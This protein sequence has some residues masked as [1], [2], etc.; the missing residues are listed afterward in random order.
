MGKRK[1]YSKEYK[2]EA[3]KLVREGGKPV[4]QAAQDLGITQTT[5][6]NWLRQWGIDRGLGP[7]NALTTEEKIEMRRLRA[8]VRQLTMERDF[9]KKAAAFFAKE[10]K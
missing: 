3:V 7:A 1:T 9:L 6:R 10:G 4:A 2:E 5:L 8:Q